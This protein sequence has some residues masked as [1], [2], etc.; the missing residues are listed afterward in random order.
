MSQTLFQ[1]EKTFF[2]LFSIKRNDKTKALLLGR[3][4]KQ[5]YLLAK[6]VLV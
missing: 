2:Q 1:F 4:F 3:R 6:G 5:W